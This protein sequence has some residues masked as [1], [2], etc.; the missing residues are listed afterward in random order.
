[1][2]VDFPPKPVGLTEKNAAGIG[3]DPAAFFD[4]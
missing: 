3:F 1:M 2:I 4:Q